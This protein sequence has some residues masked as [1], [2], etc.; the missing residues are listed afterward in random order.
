MPDHRSCFLMLEVG[1][2]S[3]RI[4]G[5]K[6]DYSGSVQPDRWESKTLGLMQKGICYQE[7]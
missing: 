4:C 3:R 6:G 7:T 1:L 5:L 2:G